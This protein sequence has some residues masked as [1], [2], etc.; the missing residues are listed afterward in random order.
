MASMKTPPTREGLTVSRRAFLEGTSATVAVGAV[1]PTHLTSA[2]P[3][4]PPAPA[5]RTSIEVTVNGTRHRVEVEDR[6]TLVELLRDHLG[7]TG[8]KIG[9]NRGECGACTVLMDGRPVYSCSQ[10]AVWTDGRRIETVEGLSQG[11]ELSPLQQ[12]FVDHNGPQC[13]FCTS[14]QL[15]SATALL[16]GNSH[17]EADDVRQSMTGNL[18]RCSNYNA[19]VEA[20]LAAGGRPSAPSV[21]DEA[22]ADAMSPLSEV[23]HETARIDAVERV[24]GRARYS[25]DVRVPGLLYGRVLRSPHPH[26]RIRRIDVSRA[27]ALPGVK[28]VITHETAPIVWGAGSVAGGRQYN[29][30]VKRITTHQRHLFNNPVRFVGDPV[31]AVAAVDRHVAEEALDLIDV[32]YEPLPFVLE[33]EEALAPG[34]VSIWP[35]GNLSPDVEGQT[36]PV[37]TRRGDLDA[38][39]AAADEVFEDTYTT[40][41]VHDAQMERRVALAEWDGDKLTLHTPTQGISNCRH[42]TARDLGMPE[43]KVR[44]VCQYMGGGFGNK[45]QNQDTDLIAAILAR[46][47]GSAVALELSRREDWL[48]MHG[49]W[50]TVQH[51]K[52]GVQRDGTVTAI[53]LRGYS[54]MGGYRKNSGGI[55][56][57]ELYRCP[58]VER[59]IYPVYTNRTVSGNF[60]A[61]TYPQGFFGIQSMMDDIAYRVG[62]DPVDFIRTNAQRPSAEMV[63]TN[64]SLD[65]CL[66]RGAAWFDWKARWRPVPGADAGPIKRGAGVSFMLF[67]SGLGRSSAI[68][69][70]DARERYTLFVGVTDVGGGA[71][72]TMGLI[73]A[74]ALGVPLSQVEVVSGD[75]D[76]CPYSV[77]ESGARTTVMTGSAVVAAARDLKRQIAEKGL[78]TGP[79]V[80]IA[81]TTPDLDSDGKVRN[82]F[83][84]HFV[85]VEA[86]ARLGHVRIT[87]YVAVH[88]SGRI[89]NQQTARD[90]I[91]GAIVQGIGQALHEDLVYDPRHGQPLSAGFYGARHMTHLD[92]PPIETHFIETDDGYG[93]FGAKYVGGVGHRAGAGCRGQRHL[94][95]HRSSDEG[96]PDH[97]GE[98]AGSAG[99]KSFTNADVG[100]LEQAVAVA[101]QAHRDGRQASFTGGGSDLLGLVKDRIVRPDVLVNLKAVTSRT[102]GVIDS[103]DQGIGIGG[104]VTLDTIGRNDRIRERY[105]V[106]AEAA[107][108]VAT[109]QVRNVATLAGNVCQRPWCWYY[110]NG[111]PCYKAGGSQCFSYAGENQFNAIFGGGPSYIVHPSDTAPALVALQATFRVVGPDGERQVPA[112]EFFVLPRRDPAREN[113]LADDEVLAGVDMSEPAPGTRST[114][115]KIMDREAWTHAIVSAAVVL[116]MDDDVCRAARIV[117]GGVAPVPWAVPDADAVLIGER[118]TP[119]RAARAAEVAVAGAQPLSKNAYKVPLTQAV[120]ER[121]ILKLAS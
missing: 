6:W 17:P 57:I 3:L 65:E 116:T 33:P 37:V 107:E 117:L 27:E 25:A 113:V 64:Y 74:E 61:P 34:A 52:V 39:F 43:D 85:E 120:V 114:Y 105:T 81:S 79:D 4:T 83:G 54:G 90:Q 91:R 69:R 94:Q 10:L 55:S 72:T 87:K 45:N 5:P 19:L 28:A 56:G 84:A 26:A 60:R 40:A 93:P 118:V 86:D 62:M 95:R 111:F 18:C 106:L 67:R 47:A 1:S 46:H 36:R 41:F 75:T 80:L 22:A 115:H 77:G 35:E 97:P 30:A 100:D 121:A 20:V 110:R 12:A 11:G 96:P 109:P 50:P 68:L 21:P 59:E 9:C 119:E 29:D 101:Q 44:I 48:G 51:Y 88:E 112:S 82:C 76:R 58:N 13:G 102:E 49:R 15:M 2:E 104:L 92:T 53:A 71:K 16:A 78:P 66:D 70:V 98:T 89:I 103:S 108:R 42:D 31:A 99:M 24:T 38:G 14:G 32:D 63:F 7:L 23:G 8:T 73:A